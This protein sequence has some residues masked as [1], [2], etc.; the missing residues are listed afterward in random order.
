MNSDVTT[1]AVQKGSLLSLINALFLKHATGKYLFK[2]SYVFRG[3]RNEILGY[4]AGNYIFKVTVE[5]LEP[6]V[7]H[8]QEKNLLN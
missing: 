3:Y 4:P 1:L 6:G 5:T 8:N 7:K 2:F